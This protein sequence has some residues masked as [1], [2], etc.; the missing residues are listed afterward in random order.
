MV[1]QEENENAIANYGRGIH[2]CQD[3]DGWNQDQ[4]NEAPKVLLPSSD[5]LISQLTHLLNSPPER[6]RPSVS[7]ILSQTGIPAQCS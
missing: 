1:T 3:P 2:L 6:W 4:L 5:C 7:L